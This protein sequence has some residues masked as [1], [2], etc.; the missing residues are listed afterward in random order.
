MP[1]YDYIVPPPMNAIDQGNA[2][3]CWLAVTAVLYSWKDGRP[4]SMDDAARRLGVEFVIHQAAG[5]L[6]PWAELALWRAR[7]PFEMQH[8]QC[9][10]ADGWDALLRAHGPLITVVDGTESGT[11]DHAVVV[12]GVKGDGSATG[13]ELLVANG[14]GGVLQRYTLRTF[15][16][17]FEIGPGRDE[18]FSVLYLM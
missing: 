3:L 5:T 15:V 2:D 6:L 17:I 9:L 1:L 4:C 11:I 12:Y 16:T 14:Q 18:L 7:G 8:Q 13:T 10:G